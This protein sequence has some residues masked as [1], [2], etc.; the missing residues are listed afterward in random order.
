LT[1]AIFS[2][3]VVWLE[4]NCVPDDMINV[5]WLGGEDAGIMELDAMSQVKVVICHD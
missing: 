4:L 3:H 5:F 2:V 1:E